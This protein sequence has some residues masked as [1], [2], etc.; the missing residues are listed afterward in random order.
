MENDKT[1]EQIRDLTPDKD[2]QG[3]GGKGK[4]QGGGQGTSGQ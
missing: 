2:P 4:K 3:G 1:D